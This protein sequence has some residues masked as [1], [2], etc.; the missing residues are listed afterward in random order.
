MNSK[1]NRRRFIKMAALAG[2]GL[3]LANSF[4]RTWAA[5]LAHEAKATAA[6]NAFFPRRM[7]SWW[8]TIDDLLWPQKAVVDKIK[9][10]AD[11]Y[12]RAGI[13]TAINF[14]FHN[15][16]DFANYFDRLHGY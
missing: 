14:G 9:K 15:R 3:Q 13:D 16:F 1:T 7:A 5:G 4:S 6:V 11:G 8:C 10:R 2:A 12:A